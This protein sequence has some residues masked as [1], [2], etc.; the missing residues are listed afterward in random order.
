MKEFYLKYYN[1]QPMKYYEGDTSS[2]KATEMIENHNND[3]LAMEKVDG[4]WSRAIITE[5][6]VFIQSRSISRITGEYGKK[7]PLVPH[8]AEE[9]KKL[10]SP[11]TVLLGELAFSDKT[12]TSRDVGSILRCKP[13]KAIDRQEKGDKL[14]LYIFDVL[15]FNYAELEHLPFDTRRNY[16]KENDS[17]IHSIKFIEN[18]DFLEVADQIWSN[19][20]EGIM[21][22]R[23]D[24][25]YLPGKRKAWLSLKL[26]KQL[27]NLD[28]L[29]IGTIEPKENY[30]GTELDNWQFFADKNGNPVDILKMKLIE[31][32]HPVTKPFYYGWKNGVIVEYEGRKIKVA[33]GLTDEDRKWLATEEA[34]KDIKSGSLYAEITGMEMTEDSIR[35]PVLI[36]LRHK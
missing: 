13:Q 18:T 33:S 17:F 34:Q 19:G 30:E 12:K 14:H 35:H 23:K 4:E 1:M 27:G 22:I 15:A 8:I 26:K 2:S 3:F 20:G 31:G 28:V 5:D 9:L 7:E 21:I 6:E 29:V 10:Y 16:I 25:Q 32:L 36:R 11:G 24:A